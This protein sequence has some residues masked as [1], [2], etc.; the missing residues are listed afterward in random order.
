MVT[1]QLQYGNTAKSLHWLVVA[2]L[3]VQFLVGWLMPDIHKG[4]T[5]GDWMTIHISFG[6]TVLSVIVVRFVWRLTHPVAAEASLPVWQKIASESVHWLLYATVLAT[7]LSG[8]F[9]ESFRGWSIS[10]FG[11]IPLPNLV[12][13]GSEFGRTVGR[14]HTTLTWVLL[15]LVGMHVLAALGHYFIYKDKV[16]QRMLPS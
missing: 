11:L 2:L 1:R 16:L 6:I 4:M 8:W 14:Y 5:P 10:L 13:Q 7:T 9:F 3:V 15:A 12:A